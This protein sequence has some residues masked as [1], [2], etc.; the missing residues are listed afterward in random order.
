MLGLGY[1]SDLKDGCID[2]L[3]D[4]SRL[5]GWENWLIVHWTCDL[6]YRILCYKLSIWCS[7]WLLKLWVDGSVTDIALVHTD[8]IWL[9]LDGTVL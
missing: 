2:D 8:K 7:W 1:T 3:E 4:Q 9:I 5:I 6:Q